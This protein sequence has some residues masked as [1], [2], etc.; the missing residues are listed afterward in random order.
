MP[1]N[2]NAPQTGVSAAGGHS[3]VPTERVVAR[4]RS[5][6]RV[7]VW[8]AIAAI[9][10]AGA[11]A[12]F[13]G[14]LDVAWQQ[15]VLLGSAVV[16]GLM[17]VLL[18]YLVWL[19]RRYTITSRRVIARSGFF[20]RERRELFHSRGYQVMVKRS[21]LQAMFGCGNVVLSTGV[22]KPVVLRDIPGVKLVAESLNALV[23]RNQTSLSGTHGHAT[24]STGP[25]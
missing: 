7:L 18:P 21:W 1:D 11:T 25:V 3:V 16:A 4:L 22:D 6:G 10:L 17:F 14:A 23:E 5:H 15:W 12:Y 19:S 2:S 8:P 9:A 20:V 13:F 24:G